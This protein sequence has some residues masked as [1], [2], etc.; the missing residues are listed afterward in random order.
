VQCAPYACIKGVRGTKK[1]G[2]HGVLY[3]VTGE[4]ALPDIIQQLTRT[5]GDE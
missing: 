2:L 5:Q 4:L 3:P 1:E